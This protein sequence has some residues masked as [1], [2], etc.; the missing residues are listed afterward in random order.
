MKAIKIIA[1]LVLILILIIA[2]V[3]IYSLSNLNGF[4]ENII[5]ETGSELTQT[6]VGVGSVD[7]KLTEGKG[8]IYNLSIA[9]PKGYSSNKLFSSKSIGLEI[10]IESITQKV[11]VIKRID[12]GAITLRAEEKNIKDTNIQAMLDNIKKSSSTGGKESSGGG[13]S[14]DVRI[15]IQRITLADST[16]DLQ[17]ETLGNKTVKL[18]G[19]T[20]RNIGSKSKGLSP[21][22][23]GEVVV[24]AML[25]KVK[26]QLKNELRGKAKE[27]L[28]KKLNDKLE[29]KLEEKLKGKLDS[30]FK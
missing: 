20:L 26:T 10:D 15:M 13:A 12:I 16:I 11:K 29:E 21:E 9:N 5:E 4:V 1:S 8:T 27:K 25:N 30:L 17:S 22:A 28:K 6:S 7:I 18:A 3:A 24:K 23:V 19:F 14:E 2:G